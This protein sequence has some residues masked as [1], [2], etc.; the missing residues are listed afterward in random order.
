MTIHKSKGLGFKIVIIPFADWRVDQ[1]DV[2]LW[3]HP[4][5]KPFN[6][7]SL[8]PVRY[9]KALKNTIFAPDYFKEKLHAYMDNLNALYVAFTRAKER[10]FVVAPQPKKESSNISGLLWNSLTTDSQFLLDTET[11][12]YERRTWRKSATQTATSAA[13]TTTEKATSEIEELPM[14]RF[15]SLSPD[16]RLSL[17]LHH[18]KGGF[19]YNKKQ[20]ISLFETI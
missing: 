6:Q 14:K 20:I 10:L 16:N 18:R 11:G 13:E 2:I 9:S 4:T 12:V 3:C 7:M 17:R 5:Q 1:K 15:Y 8:V 19:F